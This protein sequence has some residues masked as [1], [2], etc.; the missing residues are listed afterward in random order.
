MDSLGVRT[1]V[2]QRRFYASRASLRHCV[3]D[4]F[5]LG[6]LQTVARPQN[7]YNLTLA[8]FR[9][10]RQFSAAPAVVIQFLEPNLASG[11][12]PRA[13]ECADGLFVWDQSHGC[14]H[15]F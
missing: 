3:T 11:V 5:V 13:R 9:T 6:G 7:R 2:I 8:N 14:S 10:E 1:E 15:I 4:G 12:V